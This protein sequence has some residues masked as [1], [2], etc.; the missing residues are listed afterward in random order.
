[1]KL[2]PFS[3]SKSSVHGGADVD[4]PAVLGEL[5]PDQLGL[6]HVDQEHLHVLLS[7]LDT[8]LDLLECYFTPVLCQLHERQQFHFPQVVLML[9]SKTINKTLVSLVELDVDL[10]LLGHK[11]VEEVMDQFSSQTLDRFQ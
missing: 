6:D 3:W 1:M 5:G 11:D 7:D 9:Q 2:L 8:A 10:Q 4:D